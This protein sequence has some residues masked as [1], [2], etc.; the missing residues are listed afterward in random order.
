[1]ELVCDKCHNKIKEEQT[2][3]FSRGKAYHGFPFRCF[4]TE[5]KKNPVLLFD[6]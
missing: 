3:I 2:A 4:E 6:D 5:Q 1:M